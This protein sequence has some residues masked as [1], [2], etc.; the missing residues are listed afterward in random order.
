MYRPMLLFLGLAALACLTSGMVVSDA[1]ALYNNV[2]VGDYENAVWDSKQLYRRGRGSVISEAVEKLVKDSIRHTMEYAYKLWTLE[3]SDIVKERFP[4]QF[5]IIL[6]DNPVKIINKRDN[7]AIKLGAQTDDAGDRIAYGDKDDKNSDNVSWRFVPIYEDKKVFFKIV[8]NK[9][10]Q[11]LKLGTAAD[12]AGD[13]SVYGASGTHS[14]RLHW[15]LQPASLDGEGP[16]MYRPMLLFLGLAALACLT[17]GMVVSDADALYNNV[18]VGDY[19]NAVW[20]S[21]QLYRRGRGSVISEAV[22]K[23]V[24]DS[25]RHTMEYAYKLWT[26][27]GS[28]I[29][30]ERFPIQFRIILGDNPVKIINKRDNLAIKLGAQTDDAGD[31]IAYGDKDDKN[32]DNVSWRFVPIYEDKKVFFKIVN[33]KRHQYLKLGTAADDAGDHSV[34]GASGTHSYRLHWY[35]Q[36]A[37]LDGEVLF[38]I[39]NREYRQSLKLSRAVDDMGD[40]T[41]YSHC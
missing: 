14:Y 33:N 40:R 18:V 10:H 22:E 1:D 21:K 25:I 13:H 28:D 39:F 11:Y 8:N 23:L 27:E 7:L 36:P 3:G 20:D 34:Y 15:Y 32:S 9:R 16:K 4:I 41:V 37:S 6:G 26:L 38:Y 30:K 31:R 12:D 19:E 24:K 35:L 2:V 29:V 5:R 17:S